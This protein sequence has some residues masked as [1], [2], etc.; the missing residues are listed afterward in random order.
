MKSYLLLLPV[1]VLALLEGTITTLPLTFLLV[2]AWEAKEENFFGAFI[3]GLIL[4]FLK[5]NRLGT[6]SLI[7]LSASFLVFL[8]RRKF[9]ATNFAYFLPFT[10]F[11][12]LFYFYFS[13][14]FWRLPG[15]FISTVLAMP[16]ALFVFW[17]LE[18]IKEKEQLKLKV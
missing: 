6:S 10:F 14:G 8:Y 7:F 18:K 15:A 9:K 16:G 13:N 1:F 12:S 3:C 5:G 17:F 4:D 2:L 11:A